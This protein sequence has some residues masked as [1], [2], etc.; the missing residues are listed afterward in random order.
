[1]YCRFSFKSYVVVFN[2]LACLMILLIL[3]KLLIP[4]PDFPDIF[5]TICLLQAPNGDVSVM[6]S[7]DTPLHKKLDN[8]ITYEAYTYIRIS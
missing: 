6:V 4:T 2:R 1:M 7:D 3:F 5:T 8:S